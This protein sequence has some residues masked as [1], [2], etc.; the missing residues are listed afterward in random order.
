MTDTPGGGA[1]A[2]ARV[3]A[4]VT[5]EILL[6]TSFVIT[7]V[8]RVQH[9]NIALMD[10]HSGGFQHLRGDQGPVGDLVRDIDNRPLVVRNYWISASLVGQL[11]FR[12]Y[13]RVDKLGCERRC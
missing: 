13:R 6:R 2:A 5:L 9:E 3:Q 8:A 12:G 10:V 11:A 4:E 7:V 1:A